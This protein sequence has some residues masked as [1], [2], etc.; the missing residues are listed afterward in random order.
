M[1]HRGDIKSLIAKEKS[2]LLLK[3]FNDFLS[4]K[5]MITKQFKDSLTMVNN[6]NEPLNAFTCVDDKVMELQWTLV[7]DE[8]PVVF[9]GVMVV[10]IFT[11]LLSF[12]F[13]LRVNFFLCFFYLYSSSLF[14]AVV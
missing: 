3:V 6:T 10:L 9:I 1:S 13:K 2:N 7:V 8:L 11:L 4:M 5:A 14:F 12:S